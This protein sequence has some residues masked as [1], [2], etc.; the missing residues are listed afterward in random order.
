MYKRVLKEQ[1]SNMYAAHGLGCVLAELG[2]LE[3]A[4][5]VFS[6]VQVGAWGTGHGA[7]PGL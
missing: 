3:E 7:V 1:P 2:H 4:K 6:R 5:E